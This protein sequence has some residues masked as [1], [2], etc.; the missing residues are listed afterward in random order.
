M[1]KRTT[2]VL[3]NTEVV[4]HEGRTY[5]MTPPGHARGR[6][7]SSRLPA[8]L[9]AKR[10]EPSRSAGNA[11]S[12]SQPAPAGSA[13]RRTRMGAP[14]RSEQQHR[15]HRG[16][17][18]S[19][20]SARDPCRRAAGWRSS[21]PA[22]HLECVVACGGVGRSSLPHHCGVKSWAIAYMIYYDACAPPV[23]ERTV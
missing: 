12:S 6:Q 2:A 4:Q 22:L 11:A 7:H 17:P 23:V 14:S 21:P 16:T 8:R 19:P 10:S 13:R 3:A 1:R 18:D 9:D 5:Q 15:Q 20:S